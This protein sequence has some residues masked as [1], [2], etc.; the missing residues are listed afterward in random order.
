MARKLSRAEIQ[1]VTTSH[2]I[3]FFK[4]KN[5]WTPDIKYYKLWQSSTS[6]LQYGVLHIP[7]EARLLVWSADTWSGLTFSPL[8]TS[9][10]GRTGG[11]LTQQTGPAPPLLT[12]FHVPHSDAEWISP[13]CVLQDCIGQGRILRLGRTDYSQSI[14]KLLSTEPITRT[15]AAR[16]LL[17]VDCVASGGIRSPHHLLGSLCHLRQ[18][19]GKPLCGLLR[20]RIWCKLPARNGTTHD[21]MA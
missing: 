17:W 3:S 2:F 9:Y 10:R 14:C 16:L 20:V 11:F 7:S 6:P 4:V 18:Q 12:C 21:F 13:L 1:W 15:P 19:S 8:T 5:K